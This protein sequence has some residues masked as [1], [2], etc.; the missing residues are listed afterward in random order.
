VRDER[1]GDSDVGTL[2]GLKTPPADW[3]R[4]VLHLDGKTV[5]GNVLLRVG[6]ESR[7]G[8]ELTEHVVLSE[9]EARDLAEQLSAAS[10][11]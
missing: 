5:A 4:S 6:R 1:E 10:R 2:Y 11:R 8:W 7:G 9:A 3:P